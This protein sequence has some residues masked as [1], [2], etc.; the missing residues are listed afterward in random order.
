MSRII[1]FSLGLGQVAAASFSFSKNEG[2]QLEQIAQS[3]LHLQE[4]V[5][6]FSRE[7]TQVIQRLSQELEIK[8]SDSVYYTLSSHRT[9]LKFFS[10]PMLGG[11][12]LDKLVS[13][14]AQQQ[15]PFPLGQAL[16]DYT[17]IPLKDGSQ[18]IFL[19]AIKHS[20]LEAIQ[21]A[22]CG[23]AKVIEVQPSP[24]SHYQALKYRGIALEQDQLLIDIG[25]KSTQLLYF[26]SHRFFVR[27]LNF[28]A[29]DVTRAIMKAYECDMTTANNYRDEYALISTDST[30]I[31]SLDEGAQFL[32]N[33]V[34]AVFK[35]LPAK[36]H[37]VTH[38]YQNQHKGGALSQVHVVGSFAEMNGLEGFLAQQLNLP[39]AK[40][41]LDGVNISEQV[42]EQLTTA[43]VYSAECF[44]ELLG[45]AISA[46][47]PM[48]GGLSLSLLPQSLHNQK[49][50][51]LRKALWTAAAVIAITGLAV[52]SLYQY[53]AL[54]A[55]VI[56]EN[57]IQS[58]LNT[59]TP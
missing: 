55:L 37:Q 34:S 7:L 4:A 9:V 35:S 3:P 43:K 11:D 46:T 53:K 59:I 38:L 16:W 31:S 39:T 58:S 5:G 25:E 24:M 56:Q 17:T 13:L 48:E 32:V 52:G 42:Q 47:Q 49:A 18:E 41:G 23:I 36:I 45:L 21:Q 8:K 10:L 19:A 14:E 15:V 40:L 22:F 30:Y 27:T 26:N 1:T 2:L 44:N 6:S 33:T 54:D 29:Q 12:D 20:S 50:L 57:N 51:K 28:G